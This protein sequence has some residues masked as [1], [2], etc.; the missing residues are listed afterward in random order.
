MEREGGQ[1][2]QGDGLDDADEERDED[3]AHV[4]APL[5]LEPERPL[6][7]GGRGNYFEKF[8]LA[9][10]NLLPFLGHGRVLITNWHTLAV[11][12][13]SGKRQVMQR[14]Q[15]SPVAFANRVLRDLGSKK[16]LLVI[17]DEAHHAYRPAAYEDDRR[18]EGM[19]AEEWSEVKAAKEEATVWVSGL[20]RIHTARR[21]SFVVDLSATPF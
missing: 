7:P 10:A 12:D 11:R 15:E 21:I 14:G 19:S 6:L 3:A 5:T 1:D 2:D 9:P 17:N 8:D 18:P 16:N 4:A 20:D 13:D